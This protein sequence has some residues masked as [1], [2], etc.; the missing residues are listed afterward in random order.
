MD[1][2]LNLI[3]QLSSLP[4][5]EHEEILDGPALTPPPGITPNLDNP[6]NNNALA[7]AII[8]LSLAIMTIAISLRAYAKIFV[9]RKV[10]LEDILS[11]IGYPIIVLSFCWCYRLSINPGFFVH[12]WDIRLRD[13]PDFFDV[14]KLEV[15]SYSIAI[16]ALK[17]AILLEWARVFSPH[18]TNKTFYWT[19]HILLWINVMFYF[20]VIVL[21]NIACIPERKLTKSTMQ[22]VCIRQTVTADITSASL[23]LVSHILILVLPQKVIWQLNM[24]TQKKIGVSLVFAAGIMAV[25]LGILRLAVAILYFTTSDMIYTMYEI[26]LLRVGE[27]TCVVLVFCIP[28]FP[29]IFRERAPLSKVITSFR[30]WLG[31]VAR[32]SKVNGDSTQTRPGDNLAISEGTYQTVGKADDLPLKN[33]DSWNAPVFSSTVQ[34][35]EGYKNVSPGTDN[36]GSI[37]LVKYSEMDLE[38]CSGKTTV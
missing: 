15:S 3:H 4:P 17:A 37:N 9:A 28:A 18:R 26:S 13:L 20:T 12:Q 33:L 22:A 34:L 25:V 30:S 10:F 36:R 5:E 31:L 27:L 16:M 6:S 1:A 14:I 38:S 35:E 7:V 24:T 11:F 32:R 29:K 19:C 23:N 21:E 2:I 8:T